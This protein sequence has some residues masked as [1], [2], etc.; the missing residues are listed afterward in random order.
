MVRWVVGSIL[1][2]RSIELFLISASAPRLVNRLIKYYE[3]LL[4][5]F[6]LRVYDIEHIMVKDHSNNENISL[7]LNLSQHM[8]FSHLS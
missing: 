7:N 8:L 5:T 2:G 4:A 6:Y 3:G 1:Y